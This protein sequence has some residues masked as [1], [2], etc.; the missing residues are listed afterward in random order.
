[1]GTLSLLIFAVESGFNTLFVSRPSNN[2]HHSNFLL[3]S[4]F[5]RVPVHQTLRTLPCGLIPIRDCFF[6]PIYPRPLSFAADEA[7]ID[8]KIVSRKAFLSGSIEI[9]S[10]KFE[11]IRAS[12]ENGG[13]LYSTGGV[14]LFNCQFDGC[15]G[16]NGGAIAVTSA[17]T[18]NFITARCCHARE[19]GAID[20]RA[21]SQSN[22]VFSNS[23]FH[24]NTAELFG[25]IYRLLNGTF[26]IHGTNST[27]A[28]AQACVGCFETKFGSLDMR[29]SIICNSSAHVFNGA[30]CTRDLDSLNVENSI[31][32]KCAHTSSDGETGAVF[33]FYEN[34]YDSALVKCAFCGNDANGSYTITVSSGSTLILVECCFTGTEGKEIH[35]KNYAMEGCTFETEVMRSVDLRDLTHG[36]HSGLKRPQGT[37]LVQATSL[38]VAIVER[39]SPRM[40]S[41]I[42]FLIVIVATGV[43]I[44]VHFRMNRACYETVKSPKALE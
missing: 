3:G 42:L 2:Y 35:P 19:G 7:L 34:P 38:G 41:I 20:I 24:F 27:S 18:M 22:V 39:D 37:R 30:I 16:R 40:V 5:A 10:S 44:L 31:F 1:M 13:A 32:M 12:N 17:F 33:L 26:M 14:T 23:L 29:F 4:L 43:L 25:D 36:Y 9:Q 11:S 28:R 21:S 15:T 6:A 8:L